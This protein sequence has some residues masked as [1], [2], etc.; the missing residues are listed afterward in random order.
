MYI[1]IDITTI[2]GELMG[3]LAVDDRLGLTVHKL[4]RGGMFT[5]KDVVGSTGGIELLVRGAGSI[6]GLPLM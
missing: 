4:I 2:Q 6:L 1:A 5:G 3:T